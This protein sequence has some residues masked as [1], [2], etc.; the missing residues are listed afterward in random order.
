MAG[1]DPRLPRHVC[2]EVCSK[3]EAGPATPHPKLSQVMG[4]GAVPS[5]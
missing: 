5:S 4:G 3:A 1:Q 2:T